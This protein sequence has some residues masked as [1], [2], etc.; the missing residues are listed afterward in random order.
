MKKFVLLLNGEL[1]LRV[2]KYLLNQ[3][4]IEIE[5][6]ILN[7][8]KKRKSD[9]LDQVKSVLK[10]FEKNIP[11]VT[12]EHNF[13]DN[14]EMRKLL[15][16]SEYGVS[17]LFGHVLPKALLES[18]DCQIINLHPSLLPIGRG[19]DPIP[20]SIIDQQKQGVTIHMVNSGLDTGVIL[21]QKEIA[22]NIGMSAG[23][24][25]EIATN[26]LLKELERVLTPWIHQRIDLIEQ[27]EISSPTRKS[28][29]LEV[30]RVTKSTEVGTFGDFLRK[31]QALTYSDGRKPLFLD[32][33][34]TLWQI[35]VSV[36]VD[37]ENQKDD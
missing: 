11:V 9:Y 26:L 1:G 16:K 31:L 35:D 10:E 34:D 3:D 7:S 15:Q 20:W 29:D 22:S 33:S 18:I 32:E 21:S 36:T 37:G 17:A 13:E 27:S 14:I 24:I 2:L 23:E 30:I 8:L 28:K 25:Y 4:Q 6:I 12:Y 5:G 19:A